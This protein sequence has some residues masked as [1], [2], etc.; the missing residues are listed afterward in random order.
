M[1]KKEENYFST[2]DSL[3]YY[4]SLPTT[5]SIF[6]DGHAYVNNEE[7]SIQT[8]NLLEQVKQHHIPYTMQGKNLC[9]Y[10]HPATSKTVTKAMLEALN[11]QEVLLITGNIQLFNSLL[12]SIES[13]AVIINPTYD[14]IKIIQPDYIIS[15]HLDIESIIL[16]IEYQVGCLMYTDMKNPSYLLTKEGV[17]P[18][19]KIF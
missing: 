17:L 19:I 5:R 11:N 4:L 3:D 18:W 6:Y 10:Y 16:C 7:V 15:N 1:K 13:N 9:F 12:E 2:P 14:Q 8:K